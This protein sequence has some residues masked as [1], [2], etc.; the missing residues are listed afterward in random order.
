[1]EVDDD[2]LYK[3]AALAYK[4]YHEQGG[5]SLDLDPSR[6]R[7]K[8][9]QLNRGLPA[10]SEFTALALWSGRCKYI[11]KL[12]RDILPKDCA[13]EIPDFLCIFEVDGRTIP[14]LVEVK[15]SRNQ[16]RS[17]GKKY[18]STLQS[19]AD[20]LG[21]P[22]LIA[23]KFTCFDPSWW[24]L[25]ELQRMVTSRGTGKANIIEIMKQNLS[26][27]L[28]GDFS[29]QI[30]QGSTLAMRI[31]KEKVERDDAGSI[32][33]M[34]GAIEDVYWETADGKRVEWV[35]LLDLLF[36]LT[37]DD[38]KVEE[39]PSHVVQK[40]HKVGDDAAFAHWALPFAF[41]PRRYFG[42]EA[43]PWDRMIREHEFSFS[44]A[45]VEQTVR[46]AQERGLAGPI[47]WLQ[48][49]DVPHF[50]ETRQQ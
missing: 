5:V 28:L 22:I 15:T 36:M 11:H 50:L 39:Y 34:V 9:R 37:Q 16:V 24:V 4:I 25:F 6:I 29:F 13:Y 2:E 30:R 10:E 1:M 38:V 49:Q 8:L 18:C 17:F 14:L 46:R 3:V 7:S 21:L 47:V 44:L 19:F 23:L 12:D 35:S 42:R 45:D 27:R 33:S 43:I 31:S 40:F 26:S 41:S 48:P 32:V 20:R